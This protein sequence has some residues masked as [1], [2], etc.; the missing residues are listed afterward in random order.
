M[1]ELKKKKTL[2]ARE[3]ALRTLVIDIGERCANDEEK[4]NKA[5]KEAL[6]LAKLQTENGEKN[7][8]AWRH[9]VPAIRNH[10]FIEYKLEKVENEDLMAVAKAAAEKARKKVKKKVEG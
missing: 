7:T 6:D 10:I 8:K 4:L 5:V 3:K 1:S 2:T 9:T